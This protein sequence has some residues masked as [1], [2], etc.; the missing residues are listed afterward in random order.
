MIR[1]IGRMIPGSEAGC[2]RFRRQDK[3][4]F[5]VP[6]FMQGAKPLADDIENKV[7]GSNRHSV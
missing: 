1:E 2:E 6:N 5:E 7:D 3:V 4:K